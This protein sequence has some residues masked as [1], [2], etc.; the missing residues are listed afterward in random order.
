M[1]TVDRH[2]QPVV[3]WRLARFCPPSECTNNLAVAVVDYML[4]CGH[5]LRLKHFGVLAYR[6]YR[7]R[8][9][10]PAG[11]W[12]CLACADEVLSSPKRRAEVRA[13]RRCACR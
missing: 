9:L 6:A 12:P 10:A 4:D 3:A 11:G 1:A 7:G 8:S 2:R 13:A 5:T